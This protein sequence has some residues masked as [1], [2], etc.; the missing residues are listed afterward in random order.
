M[1]HY[2]NTGSACETRRPAVKTSDP[3]GNTEQ[4][5]ADRHLQLQHVD[6]S[7]LGSTLSDNQEHR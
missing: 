6:A 2:P 4:F 3:A 1:S 7:A 5:G